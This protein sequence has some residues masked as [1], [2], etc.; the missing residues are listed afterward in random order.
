MDDVWRSET[1]W[2][3]IALTT[4]SLAVTGGTALLLARARRRYR[5][6]LEDRRWLLERE[7]EAA[8]RTAVAAERARIA[9]E[10]HDIVSHKV[11]LMVVQATAAREV[12]TALPDAAETALQA[13]E[14]AGRDAMT[15]LRHLLGLLAPSPDGDDDRIER[16]GEG[17]LSGLAPQ[18]SLSQL[19]TLVDR[20]AFAGL[21]VEVGISGQPRPL[22]PGIDVTA[23]RI[24]QE[25]LTNALKY[26]DGGT[27]TVTVRYADHCL[28]VEVLNSGPS[29]LFAGPASTG[30]RSGGHQRRNDGAGH[31]LIGLRERVALYGGH[32]DARRRVGGG[33]R[34]RARI[35]LERP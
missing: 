13:V 24:V 4:V 27:A 19:G 26:G 12:L 33:Y 6:V 34:V 17:D 1:G 11:S 29:V 15:E 18:P 3:L 25:A 7:R 9:R 2:L 8:A 21:P 28:R 14:G 32:F 30:A 5:K 23:Y 35:P 20:I 22:P 31:G 16:E 10:L